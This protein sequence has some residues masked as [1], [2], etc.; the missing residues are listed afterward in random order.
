MD[1]NAEID[2]LVGRQ[3]GIRFS[4]SSLRFHRALHGVHGTPELR[5]DTVASRVRYAAP[6][7]RNGLVEDRAA[8]GEPLRVPTSSVPMSRL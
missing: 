2:L 6:V 3:V 7:I 4:Q 8:L 5:K 1:A